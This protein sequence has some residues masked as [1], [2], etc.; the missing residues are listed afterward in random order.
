MHRRDALRFV[1]TLPLLG[2]THRPDAAAAGLRA[3]A[4]VDRKLLSGD[5]DITA[6]VDVP[7]DSSTAWETLTDYNRLANFV[8]DMQVSRLLSR[9][10]EPIRIYQ[11]GEKSWLMLGIPLELVFQMDE[12]PP[13]HIRFRLL[14]GNI[15]GMTGEWKISPYGNWVRISYRAYVVPGVLS[16]RAPGD[17]LLIERDIETMLRAIG[18]EILRR[19]AAGE[20]S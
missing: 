19:K 13:S 8:P 15:N 20:R 16:L 4:S 18:R 5:I 17:Y 1:L 9:P 11:R 7:A 3:R 10:G 14:T 2:M 12:V 6:Y